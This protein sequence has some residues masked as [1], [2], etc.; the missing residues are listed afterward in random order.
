MRIGNYARKHNPFISFT[1]VQK[2]PEW[3]AKIVNSDQLDIDIDNDQV[4][5]FVFFTPDVSCE[6]NYYFYTYTNFIVIFGK[7]LKTT[8]MILA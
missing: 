3:C 4:P 7:R 2:N 5:Q 1:N 6:I 8:V